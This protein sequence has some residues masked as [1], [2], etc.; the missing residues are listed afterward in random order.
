MTILV[1]ICFQ[2]TIFDNMYDWDSNIHSVVIC[3][4]QTIF[5]N[6]DQPAKLR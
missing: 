5:D 1:V 2:Q 4:Q 3:F 6:I